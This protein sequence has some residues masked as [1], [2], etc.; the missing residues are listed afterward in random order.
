MRRLCSLLLLIAPIYAFAQAIS[1][2][3]TK[4]LEWAEW[5]YE[6]IEFKDDC[7]LLKGYFI[8]SENG[9]WVS[10]KM[11]ET[12]CTAGKEYR[13]IY[14]TLPINKHPRT[15]YKGGTKV[16]FEEHFEPIF[17]TD[18]TVHI[19]S[20]DVSFPV[21]FKNRTIAK[22]FEDLLPAYENHIDTLITQGKYDIAAYLLNKFVKEVWLNCT[23]KNKKTISERVLKKYRALDFFL[24]ALPDDGGYILLQFKDT[25]HWL[26][27][28]DDDL[29]LTQLDDIS[30]LKT[31]IRLNM[32]GQHSQNVVEWCESLITMIQRYGKYNKCYEDALSLYRKALVI[33][34]QTQ[35][36]PDL[37]KKIIEVCGHLYSPDDSQYLEH[38]A[39]IASDVDIRP[40]KTSYETDCGINIWKEVRD[41]AKLFFPDSWKY[42]NALKQIADYNYRRRYYDVALMQ[43]LSIDSL[44]QIK[45]N[46]WILEVWY[47]HEIL[48]YSQSVTLVDLTKNTLSRMIGFCYDQMGDVASTI[49][50]DP[51]NPYYHYMLGNDETL[52]TLCKDMY[53]RS[54]DGLKGIVK[55]PT[56]ISPGAYYEEVFDMAYAPALTTHIPYFAYKTNFGDLCQMAYNGA[57]ITKEFRLTAGNRLRHYLRT[58]HDSI[59]KGYSARIGEEMREYKSLI[60]LHDL[61]AL[62]K[63]WEI[64]HQ[65]RSLV[66][67]LDSIGVLEPLFPKWTEV[68][69]SLKNKELAIEFVEFPLW[70]QNQTMLVALVLRKNYTSP[71]LIPIF[72]NNQLKQ[73]SDTLYY[74]CQEMADLVWKPL[75]PELEGV[76]TIYFSPSGALYNI[77]IEYLP[78]MEQYNIY[79]LSSTRELVTGR[80]EETIHRAV[81]YGGLDYNATLDASAAA[82]SVALLDE[83]FKERADVRGMSLR[84]GKGYLEHSKVEVGIIGEELAKAKWECVLDTAALGTEESFKALSGRGID[85]L[86]I[87][88]HGFYY[89][90][91]EADNARYQFML[92]DDAVF[93]T[94][95]RALT[96]SGLVMSGANHILNDEEL[97][98]NVEDGIL[99]A[100]EIAD[101]DL[102]GLDL[103]VLSACQT[104]LGDIAQSEGVF[105]LQ[106][107][108][109]KAGANSILMSLWEVKDDA[110]QILMT[111]FYRNLLSGQNK[112]QSL[113]S[114]QKHLR[115]VEGG[116]YDKPECWAAFI[117][118]DGIEQR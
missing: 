82:K 55:N 113:L 90:E 112:R 66:A 20:H 31:N 36:I 97:P 61:G 81:L 94:E 46:E 106:R 48:S 85:C 101:V 58:T 1:L 103:V 69:N 18:G 99:T 13:I 70:N 30:L 84:G 11:D 73:V 39:N 60:K 78:G 86:H 62:D 44:Y 98:D 92:T 32:N 102:R 19:T 88:T 15:T 59:S 116:K 22:P 56:I 95:D 115:E 3:L 75:Q 10:S 105:G 28:A 21:P 54:L 72:E 4:K 93:S 16:Y 118:L 24:N 49:K 71:R 5:T 40:S 114:A 96:R 25:Y 34:N 57:L 80:K 110:T 2:G 7:T 91:E 100:K 64:V 50:H 74:Q 8:P 53:L 65:Q 14:T 111:Q 117:L 63:Y 12:L 79:R 45:R 51:K 42:A 107:G 68:R 104:G 9:C 89:T 41:K 108:F 83:S 37:D 35:K 27:F 17:M 47:D 6:T 76:K 23:P 52:L 109:K 29:L 38:L 43:Y 33:D 67:Y 87:S 26:H 77:G